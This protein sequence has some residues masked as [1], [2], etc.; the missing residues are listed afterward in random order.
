M[1]N[2]ALIAAAGA[3]S[4][5]AAQDLL[6]T[7]AP[8]DATLTNWQI[9]ANYQGVEPTPLQMAWADASFE[10]S[11]SNIVMGAGDY[12]PAY[13]TT[14]GPAVITGSGTDTLSFVGNSNAFFGS[15][16]DTNPLFVAN[17]TADSVSSLSLVGQNSAIFVLA[18]FGDVRLYQDAQG[19]PGELTFGV[20]IVPA[21]ASA[22]L[23]GLGG[24]AATRRRR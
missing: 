9:T 14:L 6:I 16:D 7:V 10:I 5:V 13:D 2:I 24:L 11:G 15:T 18:P 3:A 20:E 17:F 12:N 1:K 19:N 8:T 4:T 21:P 23:L 22:A